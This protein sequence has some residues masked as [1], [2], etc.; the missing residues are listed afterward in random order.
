MPK[1]QKVENTKFKNIVLLIFCVFVLGVFAV[2][3]TNQASAYNELRAL[4]HVEYENLNRA[5]DEY[6]DL[7]YQLAHFDSDA[8]V[9]RLARLRLGWL[10]PDEMKLVRVTE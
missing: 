8:Y 7:Q 1:K 6:Q 9:E 5:L 3:I 2:L 4:H 10:R